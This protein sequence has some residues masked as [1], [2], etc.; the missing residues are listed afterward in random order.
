MVTLS[1]SAI[2]AFTTG[3]V[4]TETDTTACLMELHVH[5]DPQNAPG[6]LRLRA[7]FN[8][9][10][11]QGVAFAAAVSAAPPSLEV[12]LTT[13]QWYTSAGQT[14]TLTPA[15]LGGVMANLKADRNTIESFCTG[16]LLPGTLTPW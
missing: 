14:G 12:D 13:G 2:L 8:Y 15:Q 5:W 7:V 11:G 1:P 10:N 3:G 4:A 6:G 16:N 9:G